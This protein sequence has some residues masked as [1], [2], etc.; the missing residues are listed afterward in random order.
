MSDTFICT[1]T[2][3]PFFFNSSIEKLAAQTTKTMTYS[4]ETSRC[5]RNFDK[6]FSLQ[7]NPLISLKYIKVMDIFRWTRFVSRCNYTLSLNRLVCF[8]NSVRKYNRQRISFHADF[9]LLLN[10]FQAKNGLHYERFTLR[11]VSNKTEIYQFRRK[12]RPHPDPNFFFLPESDV[13]VVMK[14]NKKVLICLTTQV[15][16]KII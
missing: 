13:G 9:L 7:P 2:S 10:L 8:E 16:V 12:E 15:S 11:T 14:I 4:Q 6:C 3:A 1:L 5:V